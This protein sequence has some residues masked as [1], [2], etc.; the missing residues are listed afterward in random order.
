[1]YFF[2][3]LSGSKVQRVIENRL[4]LR[5]RLL[6]GYAGFEPRKC[7]HYSAGVGLSLGCLVERFRHQYVCSLQRRHLKVFRQN[8]YHPHLVSVDI[9]Q[10]VRDSWIKPK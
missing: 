6:D 9:D 1:M 10:F 4:K 3:E 7:V 8:A 2:P 5:L